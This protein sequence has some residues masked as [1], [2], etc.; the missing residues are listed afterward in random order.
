MVFLYNIQCT[1]IQ[2]TEVHLLLLHICTL[3]TMVGG[4]GNFAIY[5]CPPLFWHSICEYFHRSFLP[6]LVTLI[7]IIIN[8][9]SWANGSDFA[10]MR[11]LAY[12]STKV[13][14]L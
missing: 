5:I 8:G 14:A 7:G 4:G 11:V 3:F 1:Y 10:C 6:V 2:F 9:Y 13:T 12:T